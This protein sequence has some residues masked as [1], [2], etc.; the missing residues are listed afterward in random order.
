LSRQLAVEYGNLQTRKMLNNR[1]RSSN[2]QNSKST[3]ALAAAVLK[4]EPKLI[5]QLGKR[6]GS[7][8]QR[9]PSLDP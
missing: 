7:I 8:S 9:R 5:S 1:P 2:I 4:E 3:S 6:A